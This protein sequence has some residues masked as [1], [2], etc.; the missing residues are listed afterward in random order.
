MVLYLQK[1]NIYEKTI[2]IILS[3]PLRNDMVLANIGD[4]SW[5]RL[6]MASITYGLLYGGEVWGHTISK[7]CYRNLVLQIWFCKSI[8]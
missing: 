5:R 1:I 7:Q 3:T 2:L 4:S 8:G 6:L